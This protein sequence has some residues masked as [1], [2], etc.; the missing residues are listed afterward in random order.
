MS[1]RY[2]V[3]ADNGDVHQGRGPLRPVHIGQLLQQNL[4]FLAIGRTLRDKM[5]TLLYCRLSDALAIFQ[6]FGSCIP[7]RSLRLQGYHFHRAD[8]TLQLEIIAYFN[9]IVGT[10]NDM[11]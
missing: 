7:S 6:V 2:L 11:F 3:N 4:D 5:K 8:S 9:I 1:T 10:F